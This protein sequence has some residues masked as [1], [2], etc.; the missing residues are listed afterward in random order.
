MEVGQGPNVDCSAKGKKNIVIIVILFTRKVHDGF[1][2]CPSRLEGVG[3]RVPAR[4]ITQYTLYYVFSFP[5]LNVLLAT[6]WQNILF[7]CI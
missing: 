6:P 4:N 5:V 1:I 2:T 7:V 3:I